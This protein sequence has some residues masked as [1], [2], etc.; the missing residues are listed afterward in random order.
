[1]FPV[2]LALYA[3]AAP[4]AVAGT[5]IAIYYL[6]LFL[7]NNLVGWLG[8][9]LEKMSGTQFWLMHAALVGGSA[10]VMGIAAR[11]GGR[12]LKPTGSS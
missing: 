11:F 6:H 10:A 9:F 12:L 4:K 1:V 5:F 2:G 3:R 7:C 8:G